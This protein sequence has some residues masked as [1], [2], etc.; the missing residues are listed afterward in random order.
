[1]AEYD[2]FIINGLVV[3]AEGIDEYDIAIRDETIVKV[4][5]KGELSPLRAKK[6]IDA[7]GGYVMAGLVLSISCSTI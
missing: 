3:T 4:V 6:V 5:P 2:L 1:M 7:K